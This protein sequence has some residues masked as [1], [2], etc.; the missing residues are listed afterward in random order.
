MTKKK[1]DLDYLT[2]LGNLPLTR[3]EKKLFQK[4]LEDSISYVEI[5]K[6]LDVNKIEPAVQVTK[7]INVYRS[8]KAGKPLSQK[9]ALSNA[10]KVKGGYFVTKRIKWE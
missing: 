1:L 7:L 3:K 4:Q 6:E 2:Q 8:D 5:L 10:A 9:Q